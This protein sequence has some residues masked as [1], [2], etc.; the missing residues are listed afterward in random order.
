MVRYDWSND[1]SVELEKG[2]IKKANTLS[3]LAKIIDLD[4]DQLTET[5]NRWNAMVASGDDDD[6]GRS[7]MMSPFNEGPYYAVQ[8]SPTMLNTQGGPRRNEKAEILRPD[9]NP[10]PRLYSSGEL[11]SI[12]SNLYQGAGNIGEC[13]AFG[14]IAGRNVVAQHPWQ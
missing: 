5:V 1:N 8:L 9:G 12:Y 10:I 13:L 2:W 4:G 3:E 6:F 7:L 11:G 14:R